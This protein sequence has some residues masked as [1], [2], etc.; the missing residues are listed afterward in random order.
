MMT[1]PNYPDN[2]DNSV[3]CSFL[4]QGMLGETVTLTFDDF[5]LESHTS[6][7]YDALEVGSLHN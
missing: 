5:D 2:Y 7:A 6:C 3:D 1:S 4:I